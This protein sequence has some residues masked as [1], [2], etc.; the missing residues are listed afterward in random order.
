[1]DRAAWWV[2]QLRRIR[3]APDGQEQQA[4]APRVLDD[5]ARRCLPAGVRHEFSDHGG[6]CGPQARRVGH[7]RSTASGLQKAVSRCRRKRC[8]R[9]FRLP[10]VLGRIIRAEFS[11]LRPHGA[12]TAESGVWPPPVPFTILL[13]KP[14]GSVAGFFLDPYSL[15]PRSA[16]AR[17]LTNASS[18]I[19]TR[20][21]IASGAQ[22]GM[23]FH[24]APVGAGPSLLKHEEVTT[25]FS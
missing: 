11:P 9:I 24:P 13:I 17:G 4:S 12:V 23:Q 5:L 18:Q 22:A 25:L 10:K 7:G 15:L 2:R 20:G 19:L 3:L 16:A 6:C 21:N 8:V 14:S 1:M